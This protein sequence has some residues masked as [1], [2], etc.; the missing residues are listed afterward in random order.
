M[1]SADVDPKLI[2]RI[3]SANN[4]EIIKGMVIA[5]DIGKL[6]SLINQIETET[7]IKSKRISYLERL[8]VIIIESD[9]IFW[10]RLL[11]EGSISAAT[12]TD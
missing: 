9:K 7:N 2:S 4:G 3:E 6:H 10:K 5:N 11:Q 12:V 1:V 8:K